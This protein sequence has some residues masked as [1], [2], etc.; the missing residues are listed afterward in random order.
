MS[1]GKD[2]KVGD[3]DIFIDRALEIEG[4]IGR[5][6]YKMAETIRHQVAQ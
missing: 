3:D 4:K 1:N 6:Q 5:G 2:S